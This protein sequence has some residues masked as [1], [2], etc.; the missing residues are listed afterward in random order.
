MKPTISLIAAMSENRVIGN[1][2]KIPW[3]IKDDFIRFKTLTTGH[4]II[5]G[6]ITFESI[7]RVLPNRTNIIVTRDRNFKVKDA[8]VVHTVDEALS[9][10][11]KLDQQDIF[12]V[13]GAQ[14]YKQAIMLADKLYLTLVKGNFTGDAYF[15]DYS[16]FSHIISENKIFTDGLE[17]TFMEL[18]R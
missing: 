3:Y 17:Y 10:A 18:T 1:K 6:R 13:G 8:L 16:E 4:P 5:M 12:I 15:P 9:E 14:I 2:G 7:G 11:E